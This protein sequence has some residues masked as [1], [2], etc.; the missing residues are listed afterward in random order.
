MYASIYLHKAK[1]PPQHKLQRGFLSIWDFSKKKM[2]NTAY[3][4][5]DFCE[6]ISVSGIFVVT[7]CVQKG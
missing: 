3:K 6:K 2:L 4:K 1:S 5:N 7:L